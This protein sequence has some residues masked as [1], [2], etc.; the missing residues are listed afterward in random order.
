MESVSRERFLSCG[1]EDRHTNVNGRLVFPG[2]ACFIFRS[3]RSPVEG[4]IHRAIT[5][6]VNLDGFCA[7]EL[8]ETVKA[9][10][11]CGRRKKD[12]GEKHGE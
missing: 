2:L 12:C 5:E 10:R 9:C 4:S 11:R 8:G 3:K 1:T 7:L 6:G